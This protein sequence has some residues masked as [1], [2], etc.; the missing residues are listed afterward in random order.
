LKNVHLAPQWLVT[1]EKRL[2]AMP[3]H[4]QFRLFLSM[5]IHPKLPSNLL[6]MGRIFVYEPAPGIKANLLRTFSTIP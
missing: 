6:R 2:H 5:E 1:L 3:A 4:N